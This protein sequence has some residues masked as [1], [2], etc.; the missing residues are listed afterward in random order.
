MI[1]MQTYAPPHFVL[2]TPGLSV[3]LKLCVTDVMATICCIFKQLA[4]PNVWNMHP[5]SKKRICLDFYE[6]RLYDFTR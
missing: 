3:I 1:M 5:L 4:M 6:F 2:V